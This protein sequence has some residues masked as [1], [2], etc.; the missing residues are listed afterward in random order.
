MQ[1]STIM[2]INNLDLYQFYTGPC[3]CVMCV[4]VKAKDMPSGQGGWNNFAEVVYTFYVHYC[5]AEGLQ[6]TSVLAR[7]VLLYLFY[8]SWISCKY[9]NKPQPI[10]RCLH[11]KIISGRHR[12][13]KY[14]TKHFASFL[15]AFDKPENKCWRKFFDDHGKGDAPIEYLVEIEKGL[16]SFGE[17][18]HAMGTGT[19]AMGTGLYSHH[20][21]AIYAY[22]AIVSLIY[23]IVQMLYELV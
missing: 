14:V 19:H 20:V 3:V 13:G 2:C 9:K 18:L 11:K 8:G 12:F 7:Q 16:R 4:Q 6:E 5:V 23:D 15:E 10:I 1:P 21:L 17:D 22:I